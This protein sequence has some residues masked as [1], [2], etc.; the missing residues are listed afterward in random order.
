MAAHERVVELNV[1]ATDEQKKIFEMVRRPK[2][3]GRANYVRSVTQQAPKET[4][5]FSST[6]RRQPPASSI[7]LRTG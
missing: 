1:N 5:I 3:T 2:A 7:T 4:L 6:R